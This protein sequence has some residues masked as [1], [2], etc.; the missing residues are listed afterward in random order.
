MT[1]KIAFVTGITGQDGSY[2][3]NL[4]LAKGYVVHGLVRWDC[5]DATQGLRQ[6]HSG[7]A[8]LHFHMGDLTDANNLSL[9]LKT[10][11][12]DEIY[13]LRARSHVKVSF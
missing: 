6:E 8:R 4:L 3:T 5:V 2:L 7:T 1:G 11:Q 13:N 12:P 9:L 10:I